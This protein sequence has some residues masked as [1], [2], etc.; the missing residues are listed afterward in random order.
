[1]LDEWILIDA[2]LWQ[3]PRGEK[4]VG[5]A[6]YCLHPSTHRLRNKSNSPIIIA[7]PVIVVAKPKS[8]KTLNPHGD[9]GSSLSGMKEISAA[10]EPGPTKHKINNPLDQ[11]RSAQVELAEDHPIF[12]DNE[13]TTSS[14]SRRDIVYQRRAST[15]PTKQEQEYLAGFP[16]RRLSVPSDPQG[17]RY[18]S[19]RQPGYHH[20]EEEQSSRTLREDQN[21]A[22][23]TRGYRISGT[24]NAF[25]PQATL[26][27]PPG[28]GSRNAS[29]DKSSQ[30]RSTTENLHLALSPASHVPSPSPDKPRGFVKRIQATFR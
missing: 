17:V 8:E 20:D 25:P 28:R 29:R 1:M 14:R 15:L 11:E 19:S 24:S 22:L 12:T 23:Y 26:R 2:D 30:R 10:I 13:S 4:E 18:G 5:R 6:L 27:Q 16:G 21:I 3:K 9:K 7:K